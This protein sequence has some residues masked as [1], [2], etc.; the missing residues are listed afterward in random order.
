[1]RF[2]E[3]QQNAYDLARSRRILLEDLVELREKSGRSQSEVAVQ[4]G[5]NRSSVCRF[6]SMEGDPR[7]STVF[8]YAHAVGAMIDIAV[9]PYSEWQRRGAISEVD[10]SVSGQW[11]QSVGEATSTSSSAPLVLD[12]ATW[13]RVR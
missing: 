3:G 6:E 2:T 8:R 5:R 9:T 12:I 7:L 10:V 13:G 4:L 1:M 11:S